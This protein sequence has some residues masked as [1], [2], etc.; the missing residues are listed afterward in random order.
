MSGPNPASPRSVQFQHI[1][2][3]T[4]MKS[5]LTALSLIALA[6]SAP[7]ALVSGWVTTN[8]DAGFAGGSEATGSPLTT[9]ADGD[10][11]A[12]NFPA[13]TLGDGDALILTGSVAF[14]RV[15]V[16]NQFRI[17][18]FD[19]DNPVTT[20]DGLGYV[21]IYAQAGT[22]GGGPVNSANGTATNPFSGSAATVIGTMTNPANAAAS[23]STI[24]FSLTIARDGA[25]LDV[26]ASYDNGGA[27]TSNVA[28][29]NTPAVPASFTYDSVAF[30]MGGSLNATQATYT[31]VDVTYVPEPSAAL[32][33]ALGALALLR[34]RR[35]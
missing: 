14:N 9:D 24:A 12:A 22:T 5:T 2:N 32:L 28:I 10:T 7:A 25:N 31:N 4:L 18:L 3:D 11:I 13:V 6:S 19:G 33:G 20:G 1:Q 17:G 8:G 23:G 35:A 26:A 27:Y 16:G 29:D 34:R 15:L 21:G 30:L